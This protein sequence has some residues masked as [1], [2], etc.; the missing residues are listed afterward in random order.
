MTAREA[1]RAS[2]MQRVGR[3]IVRHSEQVRVSVGRDA[4]RQNGKNVTVRQRS[5]IKE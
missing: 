1:A 5:W 3:R 4:D 2:M